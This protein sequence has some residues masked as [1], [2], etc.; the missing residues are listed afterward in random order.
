[1]HLSLVRLLYFFILCN[2]LIINY[3]Y[4]YIYINEGRRDMLKN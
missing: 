2:I 1:M 4:K 3:I